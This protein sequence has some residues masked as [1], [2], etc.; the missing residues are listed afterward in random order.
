MHLTR[1]HTGTHTATSAPGNPTPFSP[2]NSKTRIDLSFPCFW[3]NSQQLERERLAEKA[4]QEEEEG[5][6]RQE[7]RP[8][9]KA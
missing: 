4:G 3:K 2:G 1:S 5:V 8:E 6:R 9:L 7:P